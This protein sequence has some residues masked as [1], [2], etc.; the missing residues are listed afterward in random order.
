MNQNPKDIII[1]VLEIIGYADD[2]QEFADKFIRICEEEAM[3]QII[4][5]L[6]QNEYNKKE[7]S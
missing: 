2:K 7:T 5:E 4:H 3:I 1:K 6:P